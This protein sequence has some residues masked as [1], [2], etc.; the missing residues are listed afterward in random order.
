MLEALIA[1]VVLSIGMMGMATLQI[2]GLR[3]NR[4]A[5]MR[6]QATVLVYDVIEQLRLDAALAMDNDTYSASYTQA[7]AG[8]SCN[9]NDFGAAAVTN[10]WRVYIR[11]QI[12]GANLSISQPGGTDGNEFTVSLTWSDSGKGDSRQSGQTFVVQL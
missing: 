12:P 2:S 3:Y 4:D 6:S 7:E 1:I 5:F 8:A 10:C 11:D 9:S